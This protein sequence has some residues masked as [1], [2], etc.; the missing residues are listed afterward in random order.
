M[1]VYRISYVAPETGENDGYVYLKSLKLAAQNA[2]EHDHYDC[3]I[4]KIEF[5]NNLTGILKM[6]NKYASHPDNG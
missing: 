6:L 1:K 3:T 5:D 2:K 4:D